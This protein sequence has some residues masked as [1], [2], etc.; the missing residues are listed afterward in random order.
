M[1]CHGS[2]A[3]RPT[4]GGL[5]HCYLLPRPDRGLRLGLHRHCCLS[6]SPFDFPSEA[7]CSLLGQSSPAWT[8]SLLRT[9]R[10]RG[11][12]RLWAC[13]GPA[14]APLKGEV[15]PGDG[16]GPSAGARPAADPAGGA[17]RPEAGHMLCIPVTSSTPAL[18][19]PAPGD[20]P[21]MAP[22]G[23]FCRD[24]SPSQ[25]PRT[26]ALEPDPGFSAASVP[27]NCIT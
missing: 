9:A 10:C 24:S 8:L 25:D 27:R 18:A 11:E 16:E 21:S 22:Q 7:L 13:S 19:S 6:H 14:S 20:T 2:Q 3:T 17:L 4:L 15:R 5:Q 12:R 1:S 26:Q 23:G